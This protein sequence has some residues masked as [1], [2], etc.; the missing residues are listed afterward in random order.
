MMRKI[1]LGAA[2][3]ACLS[4]LWPLA[5]ADPGPQTGPCESCGPAWMTNTN[6]PYKGYA[7][8]WAMISAEELKELW[9]RQQAWN[10]RDTIASPEDAP[11]RDPKL[12]IIDVAKPMLQYRGGGHIP[13]AYNTW[14]PD[15]A[16][17]ETFW[18]EEVWAENLLDRAEFQ[19][20]LRG[21][22]IDN[23]SQVVL[24]DHK[25]DATRLWWAC[26][27]YGFDTRVLDGGID[28]WKAAGYDVDRL[29]SPSKPGNGNVVLEGGLPLLNVSHD[30][31]WR[32]KTDPMWYLWDIRSKAEVDGSRDRATRMGT[33][34]WQE[35]LVPW[36]EVHGEDGEFLDAMGLKSQVIDKYDFVPAA[37]HVFFCQSGV[38][39]TQTLFALYAYGFPVEHL[40]IYDS[41]W[42][43]WG[44]SP[45]LPVID[46]KGQPVV[47][48][49]E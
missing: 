48:K 17:E 26:K 30:A 1:V 31:V 41:S 29:S 22:G 47:V 20:F 49:Q 7:R 34:P 11:K 6:P 13:G 5:V 25:Y 21:F 2:A 8:G 19:E 16:S 43:Y 40:H 44:N 15:Y 42:I 12:V 28:A 37:H 3:A 39:V 18:E 32:C 27:L 23:D 10:N 38:R 4:L 33:I 24:Y 36:K 14:R 9:D 45:D 46:E 35:A